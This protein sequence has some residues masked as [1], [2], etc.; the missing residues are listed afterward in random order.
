MRKLLFILQILLKLFLVFMISFIW[1]RF[2]LNSIWL[3]LL[4]SLGITVLFEIIHRYF[5]RKSKSKS[6]LKLKEKEDA[7]NIF[8]SLATSS[9]YL[10]FYEE[11]LKT[12]HNNVERKKTYLIIKKEEENT[13]LFPF[14][15]L[16]IL[17]PEH[18]IEIIKNINPNKSDKITIICHEYDKDAISFLK[19]FDYNIILLDRFESY[20]LYKEYEFFPKITQEYKKE[21][22]LTFKDLLSFAF[23]RSRTKGYLISSFILFTTSFFVQ[24]NVYYCVIATLLLLLALISYINPKYNRKSI[25]EFI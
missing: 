6:N 10:K 19:N 2:F 7:E 18:M 24:I 4:I 22:R 17:K 11:M 8:F 13:V 12:R 21:A 3:S 23:N 25:K 15:K 1:T 14:L 5:Q 9:D 16:N 20:S